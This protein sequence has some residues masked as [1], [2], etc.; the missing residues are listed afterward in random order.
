MTTCISQMA[1]NDRERVTLG[2][3]L[4]EHCLDLAGNDGLQQNSDNGTKPCDNPELPL[5]AMGG[6]DHKGGEHDPEPTELESRLDDKIHK[7]LG[8]ST[9]CS[10][11][12]DT[13]PGRTASPCA[14]PD[15]GA[16]Y[17]Y[18]APV[19]IGQQRARRPIDRTE[20]THQ[21]QWCSHP[22]SCHGVSVLR[23]AGPPWWPIGFNWFCCRFGRGML[24][25]LPA[26]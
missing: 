26:A 3:Q 15:T 2:T 10:T 18:G 19:R 11:R 16:Y 25:L 12:S 13:V 23:L 21:R 1:G 14:E 6:G 8:V 7:E 4:M 17:Q 24:Y 9:F 22:N 5:G 20:G